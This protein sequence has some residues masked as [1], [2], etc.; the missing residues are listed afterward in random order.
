MAET[1]KTMKLHIHPDEG[2]QKLLMEFAML[3]TDICNYISQFIF[4]CHFN[5]NM[6]WLHDQLYYHIREKFGSKSQMTLSAFRTAIARYDAVREQMAQNPYRYKGQDGKWKQIPR[7]LEWLWKPVRFRRPQADLVRGRDYSFVWKK[8]AD[9]IPERMLSLN[10]LEGRVYVSYDVPPF[11]EKYFDGS[12]SFGTGKLVTLN[13]KWYFHIPMT[14]KS[15]DEFSAGIVKHVAGIDRGLRF[16][17][18]VYDESGRASFVDGSGIL[19]KRERFQQVRSEL[20][21]KGTKSAKRALQRLSGRENR[22]MSDVNH[23]VSKAL[24]TQYGN[25]TLFAMEDL[26]GVSFCEE[27]LSARTKEGR[28]ELRSWPFYQLEQYLA[29]KAHEAG[30]EVMRVSAAY[31]SQRCPKCGRIRK[32]NRDHARHGYVC[33]QCGYRSNDD[34]VGAMNIYQLG[35]RYLRGEETPAFSLTEM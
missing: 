11:F 17:V 21:A 34:R 6:A 8:N 26:S 5:M 15:V 7:T 30:S 13:G 29:Y 31:T 4:D 32:E 9:N 28:R 1:V 33:D 25:N 14:K 35:I 10:T 3:Y 18:T 23:Q 19:K 2:Q 20:Q 12:W 16:L 22:W 24:V 27:N